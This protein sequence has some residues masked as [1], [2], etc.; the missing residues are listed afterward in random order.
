M[1]KTEHQAQAGAGAGAKV[2]PL[3]AENKAN[4]IKWMH[5]SVE[6][7]HGLSKLRFKQIERTRR[8]WIASSFVN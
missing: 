2:S 7:A 6:N 1:R 3:Q 5:S 4:S 8:R